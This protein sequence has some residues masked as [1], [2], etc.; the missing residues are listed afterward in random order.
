MMLALEAGMANTVRVLAASYAGHLQ[1]GGLS[2]VGL[3][4]VPLLA[5]LLGW[6]GAFL[7]STRYL[8]RTE[9]R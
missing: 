4:L 9:S 6:L 7:A 1:F 5:A 3:V 8:F 2:P